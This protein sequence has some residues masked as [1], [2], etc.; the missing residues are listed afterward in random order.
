ML[1]IIYV[2]H[3]TPSTKDELLYGCM[4]VFKEPH[5]QKLSFEFELVRK[6]KYLQYGFR[7]RA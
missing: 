1:Y 5:A 7:M 3:H 4:T 2:Y 6:E